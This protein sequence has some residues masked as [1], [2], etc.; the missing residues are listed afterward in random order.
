MAHALSQDFGGCAISKTAPRPGPFIRSEP[1]I[2]RTGDTSTDPP[3]PATPTGA[4]AGEQQIDGQSQSSQSS[5]S[6][7]SDGL[8]ASTGSHDEGTQQ[9]SEADDDSATTAS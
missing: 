2:A 3:S 7:S 9:T 6:R 1:L 8:G 5:S 4:F